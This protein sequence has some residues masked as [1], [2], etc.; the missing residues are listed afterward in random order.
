MSIGCGQNFHKRCAYKIPNNCTRANLGNTATPEVAS[1]SLK[2]SNTTSSQSQVWSGRPLWMDRAQRRNKVEIPH[3]FSV[4]T[5]TIPTV[6]QHC[7]KLVSFIFVCIVC[8]CMYRR[9]EIIR[10]K[11]VH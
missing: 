6:C 1:M 3:T 8:M 4:H 11:K 10:L 9:S 2:R 5:Y 7:K